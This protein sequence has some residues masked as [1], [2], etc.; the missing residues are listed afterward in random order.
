MNCPD[1]QNTLSRAL[2]LVA[3]RLA[4]GAAD[5]QSYSVV[6]N[7]GTNVGDPATPFYS[8]IIA[9]G[10]DGNL[11]S[12]TSAGGANPNY[13]A[14]YVVTPAGALTVLYNFGPYGSPAYPNGGLTLG[15]DG[16]F[17]GTTS[18]GGNP[19]YGTVFQIPPTG[20]VTYL[21]NFTDGADGAVPYAPPNQG[22]DGNF[23]GT[24]S[25]GVAN[26]SIYKITPSG[27]LT[28]LY[29]FDGTHGSSPP[30]PLIQGTD[31]NFYGTTMFGGT[32]GAGVVFR[33]TPAG[34]LTVLYNFDGTHGDLPVGPLVQGSDGNFYGT[35][36]AGGAFLDG[37]ILK[38]T[39]TG[40]L[41]V[42]HSLNISTEGAAPFG[43]LVQATD[44]NF[45]GTTNQNGPGNTN[46]PSGCGTIFKITPKGKFSLVY[47]FDQTTGAIPYST[48]M[49][50]TNGLLYGT[51]SQGGVASNC[52]FSSCGVIYSLNIGAAPFAALVS[53]SGKVGAKIGILGQNF[54][55]SSVVT[56]GSLAAT[57]VAVTGTTFLQAT[58]PSGATTGAVTV[59]TTAGTLTSSKTFRV[60]PQLK[61]FTPTSGAVGS[62]VTITGVSLTQTSKVAFGGVAATSFTVNSD[63]Q[64]SATVPIGAKTGKIVISTPGGTASSTTNFT[65]TT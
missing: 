9:Q 39:P 58:V 24:T 32:N 57:T 36:E 34:K 10:R 26:G 50:H 42:L 61:S 65:V 49:Q 18:D 16:N 40:K 52:P 13:G 21:Y 1:F 45:Y 6:Y 55:K 56:F 2:I 5:A 4:V 46:C 20:G 62:V 23:Y 35:T 37:V 17:Y 47:S 51:A 8:G 33:I 28:V 11:Y 31:G 60:T 59:T 29:A 7:F 43:G 15:S 41:T 63:T 25:G 3:L 64:V 27:T 48:I 14:T 54:S 12:S 53:T 22:A 30:D 44:G 38:M 19:G